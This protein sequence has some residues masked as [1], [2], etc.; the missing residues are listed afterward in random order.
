MNAAG[1]CGARE[2]IT[3]ALRRRRQKKCDHREKN[4]P[5][6]RRAGCLILAA[7]AADTLWRFPGP[8][9]L[10]DVLAGAPPTLHHDAATVAWLGDLSLWHWPG[11][12]EFGA[13]TIFGADRLD[14]TPAEIA[15]WYTV[16]VRAL[17]PAAVLY[18]PDRG[19]ARA[20]E[21]APDAAAARHRLPPGY[22]AAVGE[23]RRAMARYDAISRRVVTAREALGEAAI[24][25]HLRRAIDTPLHLLPRPEREALADALDAALDAALDS[26]R[27]TDPAAEVSQP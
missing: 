4:S 27:R 5:L 10:L 11:V 18:V 15:G 6:R 2:S 9:A 20:I 7:M 22:D 14:P 1:R 3:K 12:A 16:P 21:G 8:I 23:M 26:K 25:H 24:A 19:C 17:D 13:L